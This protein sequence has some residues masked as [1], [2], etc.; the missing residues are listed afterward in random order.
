MVNDKQKLTP[1]EVVRKI[2][3]IL[4]QSMESEDSHQS[5]HTMGDIESLLKQ[6]DTPEAILQAYQEGLIGIYAYDAIFGN[7]NKHCSKNNTY[8]LRGVNQEMGGMIEIYLNAY[9]SQILTSKEDIAYHAQ[10]SKRF[11]DMM[12]KVCHMKIIHAP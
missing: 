2:A 3:D 4:K 6:L 8:G 11:S 5:Q 12:N 10:L 7:P 9:S 1:K